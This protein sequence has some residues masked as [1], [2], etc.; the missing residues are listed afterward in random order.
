MGASS[1]QNGKPYGLRGYPDYHRELFPR[2][3]RKSAWEEPLTAG[4]ALGL[5]KR[6][7]SAT[8]EKC[9]PAGGRSDLV[10]E[11]TP[12]DSLWIEC[13]T[14][15]R[16]CLARSRPGSLYDYNYDGDGCYDPG[17]GRDAWVAGV[18]DIGAKDKFPKLLSL[19]PSDASY[20]GV[21]L[22]GF[23]RENAPLTN[24]ELD[25]LLPPCLNEWK[26]LHGAKKDF[27]GP[28]AI[29]CERRKDSANYLVLVLPSRL[30]QVIERPVCPD[31]AGASSP[32]A[33]GR[34]QQVLAAVERFCSVPYRL[35]G[36]Q[37]KSGPRRGW[38]KHDW[39]Y[40]VQE[41]NTIYHGKELADPIAWKIGNRVRFRFSNVSNWGLRRKR[42]RCPRGNSQ[43][44]LAGI[45]SPYA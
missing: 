43:I 9:Y 34:Y 39:G 2:S 37:E 28:I 14:A 15:F 35:H 25:D 40:L 19:D 27:R 11:R 29:R 18:A 1:V 45:S 24:R 32:Q 36:G 26:A 12:P 30:E 10:V 8:T 21:L 3:F 44:I 22:L 41:V 17:Q 16:Q 38:Y 20:V 6:G 7:S 13:K 31:V 33:G 4:I 23:D 5:N 42:S